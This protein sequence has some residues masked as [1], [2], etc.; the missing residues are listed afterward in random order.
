MLAGNFQ[1]FRLIDF[2]N[3]NVS[4]SV[5]DQNLVALL[6][7]EKIDAFVENLDL[8]VNVEVIVDDHLAASADQCAA[9]LDGRQPVQ[10]KVRDCVIFEFDS[11]VNDAF[12]FPTIPSNRRTAGG[13]NTLG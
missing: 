12:S 10:M 6:I 13:P 7:F 2:G 9:Q 1:R 3:E 4:G 8:V 5:L 11:D